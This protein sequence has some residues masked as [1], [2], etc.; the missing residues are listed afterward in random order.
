MESLA[1]VVAISVDPPSES[2]KLDQLL[3]KAFPLLRDENLRVI[4]PYGMEH[5]MGGDIVGNMGYV[6]IDG[7]GVVRAQTIDPVFG[8]NASKIIQTLK[9]VQA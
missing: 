4:K 2:Q 1:E 6:I 8:Q 7:K 5:N 9:A 3:G